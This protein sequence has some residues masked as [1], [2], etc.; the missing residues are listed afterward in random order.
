MKK[1][2]IIAWIVLC[3]AAWGLIEVVAGK[4]AYDLDSTRVPVWLV[5][6]AILMLAASRAVVNRPGAAT[7]VAMVA[8][9]FRAVNAEPYF[10][11]ILGIVML[12]VAF[13]VAA[14]L[15]V[16]SRTRNLLRLAITGVLTVYAA[17]SVFALFSTY[18]LGA[19]IWLENGAAK[20][21]DHVFI[22]GSFC[23][24]AAAVAAP[25]GYELGKAGR[26]LAERRPLWALRGACAVV[27][28]IWVV[29]FLV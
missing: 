20:L 18:I 5:G 29:G 1:S 21:V 19:E 25:L 3:G 14:T 26:Q 4:I 11:H 22:T 10:C 24:L 13:D 27:V 9:L 15:L 2:Y 28:A 23:A 7:A 17:H 8:G 12:G 16:R 6:W